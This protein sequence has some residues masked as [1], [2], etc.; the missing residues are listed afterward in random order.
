MTFADH[1][2]RRRSY[3]EADLALRAALAGMPDTVQTSHQV[4]AWLRKTEASLLA[5]HTVRGAAHHYLQILR[6]RAKRAAGDCGSL[7]LTRGKRALSTLYFKP[8]S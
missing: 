4:H 5:R 8:P 6:E 7:L 2:R 1:L 3:T